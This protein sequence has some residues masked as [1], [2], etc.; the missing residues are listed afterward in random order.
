VSNDR[1]AVTMEAAAELAKV[2]IR[3]IKQWSDAGSLQI[4]HIGDMRI[5]HLDQVKA[6]ASMRQTAERLSRGA[7]LRALL[8]EATPV[9]SPDHVA[10]LQQ[11]VRDRSESLVFRS[12]PS[13][14]R[15]GRRAGVRVSLHRLGLTELSS[16]WVGPR[17]RPLVAMA[18]AFIAM[19]F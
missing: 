1:V 4:E 13:W 2:D 11:L 6:L 10:S 18:V 14:R 8:K 3:T 12:R 19:G 5:V 9:V 15:D 7:S 16:Y 17:S